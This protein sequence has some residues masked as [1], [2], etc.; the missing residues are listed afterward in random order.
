MEKIDGTVFDFALVLRQMFTEEILRERLDR[1]KTVY[2]D[3][4]ECVGFQ[5]NQDGS[6]YPVS[7]DCVGVERVAIKR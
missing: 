7:V 6:E 2:Y 3:C 1:K 4:M 5:V